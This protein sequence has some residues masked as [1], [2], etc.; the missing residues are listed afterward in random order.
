MFFSQLFIVCVSS[1]QLCVSSSAVRFLFRCVFSLPLTSAFH[2]SYTHNFRVAL[3]FQRSVPSVSCTEWK[4]KM[5]L[6]DILDSIM[7]KSSSWLLLQ[8]VRLSLCGWHRFVENEAWNFLKRSSSACQA[9]FFQL[10]IA[11]RLTRFNCSACEICFYGTKYT[12]CADMWRKYDANMHT[13][14]ELTWTWTE[15]TLATLV[16]CSVSFRLA[17]DAIFSD[18]P[19]DLSVST[20]SAQHRNAYFMRLFFSLPF[21]VVVL[22]C[23]DLWDTLKILMQHTC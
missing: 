22:F 4:D 3:L 5:S 23:F 15:T 16:R 12:T 18:S 21:F 20:T 8:P 19:N 2:D 10:I 1:L 11:H 14:V 6:V 9:I 17:C 7:T 13:S